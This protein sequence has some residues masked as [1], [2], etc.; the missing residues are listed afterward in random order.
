MYHLFAALIGGTM[1]AILPTQQQ[2]VERVVEPD[3]GTST[4]HTVARLAELHSEAEETARLANLLGR[5]IHVAVALPVLVAAALAAGRIGMAQSAAWIAFV[6]C[7]SFAIARAYRR[8]IWQ[9]FEHA[10]LKSF[11]QDLGAIL[12]FGGFAWGAG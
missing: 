3:R 12:V 8:T 2:L 9:P 7:A 1:A 5:S 6:L 10:A 11:S 4:R